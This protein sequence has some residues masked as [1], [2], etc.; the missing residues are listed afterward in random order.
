MDDMERAARAVCANNIGGFCSN[1]GGDLG[2]KV[3][4]GVSPHWSACIANVS[5]LHL[6]GS[7]IIAKAVDAA[8][9]EG[10]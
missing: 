4:R 5:Q 1:I 2:C 6:S 10:G 7:M 8:L 3:G 9:N